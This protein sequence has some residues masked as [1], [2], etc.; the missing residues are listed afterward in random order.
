[1][2]KG[3]GDLCCTAVSTNLW[4]IDLPRP[5]NHKILPDGGD[6]SRFLSLILAFS[7]Y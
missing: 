6:S 1:M 3:R 7:L 5:P 4:T 2:D